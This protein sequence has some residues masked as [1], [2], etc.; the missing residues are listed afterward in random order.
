MYRT[1]AQAIDKPSS[2]GRGAGSQDR[3]ER[4][5]SHRTSTSKRARYK[6]VRCLLIAPLHL[7]QTCQLHMCLGAPCVCVEG[8]L[9]TRSY[10]FAP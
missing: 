8:S 1:R 4:R 6:A 7:A 9:S 5:R 2:P 3:V 10:L